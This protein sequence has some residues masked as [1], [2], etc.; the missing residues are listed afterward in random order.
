VKLIPGNHDVMGVYFLGDS[1]SCL[2]HATPDV[3]IDNAP[4]LRKYY[5]YGKNAFM[6][7]HG[8]KGKATDWPLLFATEQPKMFG[9]SLFREV[10][11]GHIHQT[12]VTEL[13]GVKIRVS[14]ALCPP[15]A[16]HSDNQYVGNV[17]GA[18]AM[19]YHPEDGLVAQAFYTVKE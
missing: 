17:R 11:V 14:P 6:F 1:L 4:T 3:S 9:S 7:T 2:F 19:V 12:R 5:A 15:D 10:H 16:W 13:H 8:E 18:E